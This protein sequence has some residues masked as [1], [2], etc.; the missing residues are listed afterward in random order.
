MSESDDIVVGGAGEHGDA[1]RSR[2]R[3]S[4]TSAANDASARLADGG[5]WTEF[6]EAL[7][8]AGQSLFGPGAPSSPH[9]IA[10]GH[11]YLLGLVA[12]GV[13]QAWTSRTPRGRASSAT[14]TAAGNGAPRTPTTSTSGRASTRTRS[15]GSPVTEALRSTF[16]SR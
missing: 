6:C 2:R 14:R 4:T 16:S 11:R 8:R 1:I 9:E 5:A 7:Q 15:I 12:S 3:R 13:R 10:E